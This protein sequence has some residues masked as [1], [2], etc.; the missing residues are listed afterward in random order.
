MIFTIHYSRVLKKVLIGFKAV[1]ENTFH[2]YEV[3]ESRNIRLICFGVH[4]IGLIDIYRCTKLRRHYWQNKSAFS[5][6]ERQK[7]TPQDLS[8]VHFAY[9]ISL[10]KYQPA[11]P[12]F[13]SVTNLFFN[14]H[15]QS[16]LRDQLTSLQIS[17]WSGVDFF[18]FFIYQFFAV[19]G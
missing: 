16:D 9:L 2:L 10:I 4:V 8:Q 19:H 15:L 1:C 13:L 18:S 12:D 17:S 7:D 3:S 6:L 14:A 5:E 11:S